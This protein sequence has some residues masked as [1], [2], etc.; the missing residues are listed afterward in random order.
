MGTVL[1]PEGRKDYRVDSVH[2]RFTS[3]NLAA[4]S[5]RNAPE[6]QSVQANKITLQHYQS[7][8][9]RL[10]E[11]RRLRKYP[12]QRL[13]LDACGI[14]RAKSLMKRKICVVADSWPGS[15]LEDRDPHSNVIGT[16]VIDCSHSGK[17]LTLEYIS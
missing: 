5:I 7:V 3:S 6:T 8:R 10:N 1:E 17:M 9:H 16:H 12:A 13:G 14:Q 2:L 15:G 11:Q 4:V